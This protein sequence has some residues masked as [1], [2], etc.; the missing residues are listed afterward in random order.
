MPCSN[1]EDSGSGAG[2]NRPP[3]GV[4]SCDR[5]RSTVHNDLRQTVRGRRSPPNVPGSLRRIRAAGVLPRQDGV[6]ICVKRRL[7]ASTAWARV[8]WASKAAR[9]R[10]PRSS[11]SAEWSAHCASVSAAAWASAA[12][13]TLAQWADHLADSE[14]RGE[15]ARAAFEAH[16][17]RAHTVEAYRRLFTQ[18]HTPS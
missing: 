3:S 9:A 4:A 15:R 14:E 1:G 10:S 2:M 18:M 16:F 7:Y 12:A 8:K 6:C 11:E 17:T 13:E 5:E